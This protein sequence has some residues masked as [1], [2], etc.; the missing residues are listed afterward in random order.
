VIITSDQPFTKDQIQKNNRQALADLAMDLRRVAMGYNRGSF[1]M[2]ERFL[3]EAV[4]RKQ[5]IDLKEVKPYLRKYLAKITIKSRQE[6]EERAED[7]LTYSTLFQ[8]AAL[9]S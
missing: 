6:P 4:K 7:F 8:N 5:E 3:I 1:R 9:R 2:A